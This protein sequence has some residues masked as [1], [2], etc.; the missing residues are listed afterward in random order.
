MENCVSE[1]LQSRWS[2]TCFSFWTYQDNTSAQ[3]WAIMAGVMP[4]EKFVVARV[5]LATLGKVRIALDLSL[6]YTLGYFY[7]LLACET[8]EGENFT[9]MYARGLAEFLSWCDGSRSQ[10][11]RGCGHICGRSV[12]VLPDFSRF[13]G[14]ICNFWV[15]FHQ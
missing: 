8:L 5:D 6:L 1:I 7:P 4:V 11:G 3:Q 10:E 9:L 14:H 13:S 15:F 12:S 2:H